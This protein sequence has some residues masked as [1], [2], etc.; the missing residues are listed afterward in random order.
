[1]ARAG[2]AILYPRVNLEVEI[3][4]WNT[5][6]KEP[7][8]EYHGV[9]VLSTYFWTSVEAIINTGLLLVTFPNPDLYLVDSVVYGTR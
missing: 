4:Q 2:L 7:A 3:V 6:E 5:G 8:L 1:M 9:I